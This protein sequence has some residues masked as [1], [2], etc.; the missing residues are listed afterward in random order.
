[1]KVANI[2]DANGNKVYFGDEFIASH[3]NTKVK[4]VEDTSPENIGI[5]RNYDVEDDEG[6]RIWN[7][8]MVIAKSTP[9]NHK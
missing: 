1:M 5:G 8:Y 9:T 4:V 2:K 3:G 7:A 6:N